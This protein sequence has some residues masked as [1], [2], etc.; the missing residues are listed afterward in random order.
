MLCMMVRHHD[1]MCRTTRPAMR[2]AEVQAAACETC[3]KHSLH[4]ASQPAVCTY[5][6]CCLMLPRQHSRLRLQHYLASSQVSWC[7]HIDCACALHCNDLCRAK[8]LP[9]CPVTQLEGSMCKGIPQQEQQKLC[10]HAFVLLQHDIQCL[11]SVM[12]VPQKLICT[13]AVYS[14][15]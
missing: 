15:S 2:P 9:H 5:A 14:I 1:V 13:K 10:L 6:S 12:S 7:C 3:H 4:C 11:C 8:C